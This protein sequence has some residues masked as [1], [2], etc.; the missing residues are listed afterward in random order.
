M[1]VVSLKAASL[2]EG[3]VKSMLLSKLRTAAAILLGAT[4]IVSGV[5]VVSYRAVVAQEK[6]P[7]PAQEERLRQE[8]ARLKNELD[9]AE[10]N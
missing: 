2:A 5:G 4:L 9:Q 7:E 6:N 8:I 1:G 10:K 3:M